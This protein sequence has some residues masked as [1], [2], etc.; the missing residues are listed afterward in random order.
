MGK[1][2]GQ[3]SPA[4]GAVAVLGVSGNHGCLAHIHE[5]DTEVQGLEDSQ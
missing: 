4:L 5:R 2:A 1:Y 3:L